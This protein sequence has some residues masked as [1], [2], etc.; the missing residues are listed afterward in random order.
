[1]EAYQCWQNQVCQYSQ[2]WL[3]NPQD[4]F[5]AISG[6]ASRIHEVTG[7]Q[8]FAGLWIDNFMEDLCWQRICKPNRCEPSWVLPTSYRAPSFSWASVEGS[9]WYSYGIFFV[10]WTY[11][12]AVLERSCSLSGK[13]PFGKVDSASIKMCGPLLSALLS[14]NH[15]ENFLS[16]HDEDFLS[17]SLRLGTA[18]CTFQADVLLEEFT[19]NGPSGSPEC[20]ARRSATEVY[21]LLKDVPVWVLSLGHSVEF[22]DGRKYGY[23]QKCLVLGPSPNEPTAYERLGWAE[24]Q[25]GGG[26]NWSTFLEENRN[27]TVT[28]V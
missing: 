27:S 21:T 8:Y 22:G 12:T 25:R 24:L 5:P 4:K 11:H 19:F 13:N 16:N 10:D 17:Y 23:S 3:T 1:M 15:D 28:I 2:R 14:S 9:V 26:W 20:S 6:I 7:S 18:L